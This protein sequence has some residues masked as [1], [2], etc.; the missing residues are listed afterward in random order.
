MDIFKLLFLTAAQNPLVFHQFPSYGLPIASNSSPLPKQ[1][2]A[3][4]NIPV[5]VTIWSLFDLSL[6]LSLSPSLH[7]Y[8]YLYLCLYHLYLYMYIYIYIYTV[9]K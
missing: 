7:L 1:K 8:L 6:S 3:T 9:S 2:K 4:M 5:Y